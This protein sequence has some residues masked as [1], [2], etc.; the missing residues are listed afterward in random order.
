VNRLL[1]YIKRRRIKIGS[2]VRNDKS[3]IDYFVRNIDDERVLMDSITEYYPNGMR[4]K[5]AY[6]V[7]MMDDLLTSE[8]SIIDL[9]RMRN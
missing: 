3:K 8:W 5:E 6:R 1:R 4:C 2:W 9:R 7:V